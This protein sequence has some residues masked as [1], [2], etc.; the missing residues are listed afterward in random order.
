MADN[1]VTDQSLWN[2]N[3]PYF[4]AFLAASMQPQGTQGQGQPMDATQ[5]PPAQTPV[6]QSTQ[7]MAPV[8][9]PTPTLS[10]QPSKTLSDRTTDRIEDERSAGTRG[11]TPQADLGSRYAGASYHAQ[12][13]AKLIREQQI[14]KDTSTLNRLK[15]PTK[16]SWGQ[17][18]LGSLQGGLAGYTHQLPELMNL[19]D[20][21]AQRQFQEKE[22]LSN[23]IQQNVS[24]L[25][26]EEM[27]TERMKQQ[28]ELS[29]RMSENQ[30]NIWANRMAAMEK[31]GAGHDVAREYGADTAAQSRTDVA[32]MNAGNKP[33]Q[34]K[35]MM[36][37]GKSIIMGYNPNTKQF[38]IPYGEAPPTY[39]QVA[40]DIRTADVLNAQGIPEIQTLRG[41]IIGP[42]GTG[43]YAHEEA[44]AG[45]VQRAG[46]DLINE[47]NAHRN[48]MGSM[49]AIIESAILGTPWADPETA[50]LR[51]Q[52]GTFAALQPSMHGFKGMNAVNHFIA[53]LGGIPNNPDALIKSIQAI[54][55]TSGAINPNLGGGNAGGDAP[56]A[57]GQRITLDQFMQE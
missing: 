17:A 27:A 53:L 11:T 22:N 43:A 13:P 33:P 35:T 15:E 10:A 56:A 26:Q 48:K 52:I 3:S 42:S 6:Q 30:A 54:S 12:D 21:T 36:I 31:I 28:M 20:R 24:G 45:A 49:R 5:P 29:Q 14:T 51:T 41:R 18:L 39:G 37:G 4:K 47:I 55:R 23:R 57:G 9:S 50:G 8:T 1:N 2:P 46:G 32:G 38:D 7:G 44:Q 25:S 19:R 40:P 16:Q 34:T